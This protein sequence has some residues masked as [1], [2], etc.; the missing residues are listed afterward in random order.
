MSAAYQAALAKGTAD[1]RKREGELLTPGA[2]E[3]KRPAESTESTELP[4]GLKPGGTVTKGHLAAPSVPAGVN[5]TMTTPSQ[6]AGAGGGGSAPSS[7]AGG[8]TGVA[9]SPLPAYTFDLGGTNE[10]HGAIFNK[11]KDMRSHS[12]LMKAARFLGTYTEAQLAQEDPKE[13]DFIQSYA[14]VAAF[15][16][17][18]ADLD[19]AAKLREF[20]KE[21]S[22]PIPEP[23][24]ASAS[25]A[26]PPPAP[27]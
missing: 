9:K 27:Q 3:P 8:Q 26:T 21:I 1:K 17:C 2:R 18:T 19:N 11:V 15:A 24:V 14:V 23:V 7:G 16:R 22:V 10:V 5:N 4:E 20:A 6:P 12:S 13:P 25:G